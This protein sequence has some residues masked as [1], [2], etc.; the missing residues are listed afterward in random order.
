[1]EEVKKEEGPNPFEKIKIFVEVMDV[2]S[3]YETG[4][5]VIMKISGMTM[6]CRMRKRTMMSVIATNFNKTIS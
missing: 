1:M 3:N 4:S 2:E 6:K 5:A